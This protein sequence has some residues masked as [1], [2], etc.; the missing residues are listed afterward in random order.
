MATHDVGA[1]FVGMTRDCGDC[2]EIA[3]GDVA[4]HGNAREAERQLRGALRQDGVCA[5]AAGPGIGHDADRV[6]GRLVAG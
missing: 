2:L 4:A 3:D 1:A 5:L 6:A